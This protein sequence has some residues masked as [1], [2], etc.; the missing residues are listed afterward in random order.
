M[1]LTGVVA[2]QVKH[3]ELLL[4]DAEGPDVGNQ[5]FEAKTNLQTVQLQYDETDLVQPLA[6]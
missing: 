2:H 5:Y 4:A 3:L 6:R 1:L